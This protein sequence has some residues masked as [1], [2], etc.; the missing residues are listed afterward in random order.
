MFHQSDKCGH[1]YDPPKRG[2][3]SQGMQQLVCDT[4]SRYFL[5]ITDGL[6]LRNSFQSKI[7]KERKRS[8]D[9]RYIAAG[10]RWYQVLGLT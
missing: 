9:F 5:A 8:R 2:G 4:Q 3:K 7:Y 6:D 10:K 1:K